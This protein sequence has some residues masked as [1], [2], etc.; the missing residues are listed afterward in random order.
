M[1]DRAGREEDLPTAEAGDELLPVGP[2]WTEVRATL[3]ALVAGAA[4]ALDASAAAIVLYDELGNPVVSVP[5]LHHD[6]LRSPDQ[7]AP[8]DAILSPVA[9]AAGRELLA[10]RHPVV[11]PTFIAAPLL[12]EGR[13]TGCLYVERRAKDRP[14]TPQNVALTAGIAA[15]AVATVTQARIRADEQRRAARAEVLGEVGREL[16]AELD[17]DRFLTVARRHL[18]R[19]FGA[20]NCWLALW[21]EATGG[22]HYRLFVD[23]GVRQHDRE[24]RFTPG[25]GLGWQVLATRETICVPDYGSECR[26]R[27]LRLLSLGSQRPNSAWLGVPLLTGGHLIGAMAVWRYHG[28]F[29]EQDRATLESLAGQIATA[30]ANARLYEETERQR[31]E[32]A[33]FNAIAGDLAASLDGETILR[34]IVDHAQTLL[35]AHQG[36]IALFEP[37]DNVLRATQVDGAGQGLLSE[38]VRPEVGLVGHIWRTGQPLATEDYLVDPRF[39]HNAALDALVHAHGYSAILGVPIALGD[40]RLGVLLVMDQAG[41]RY[42][43]RDER[44]LARL[45]TQAALAVRN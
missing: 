3:G 36:E 33:A 4:A 1:H 21:D 34:R 28:P 41:R 10:T 29:S 35:G 45:A 8:N 39:P 7:P 40:E 13:V 26:R 44:L 25:Q 12:H 14:F 17:V 24:A 15:G 11:G 9:E 27:G 32:E 22:A 42:T 30:L 2:A 31:R 20:D 6:A 23:D 18:A 16:S 43:P 19:L 5:G 37:D 38:T